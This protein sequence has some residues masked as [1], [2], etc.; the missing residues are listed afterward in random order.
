MGMDFLTTAPP[1]PTSL[2]PRVIFLFLRSRKTLS[3]RSTKTFLWGH[4]GKRPRCQVS[5]HCQSKGLGGETRIRSSVSWK[6]I[7]ITCEDVGS[8]GCSQ[9]GLTMEESEAWLQL[10][11][12]PAR[13][14]VPENISEP[15]V[16][17]LQSVKLQSYELVDTAQLKQ[18]LGLNYAEIMRNV[19]PR[20]LWSQDVCGL[21]RSCFRWCCSFDAWPCPFLYCWVGFLG[22]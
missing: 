5:C 19:P 7:Q 2:Q 17:N 16:P 12:A 8:C 21:S 9:E 22:V 3:C 18:Q 10:C 14:G 20:V 15:G 13:V 6:I 4:S 11:Q 1:A